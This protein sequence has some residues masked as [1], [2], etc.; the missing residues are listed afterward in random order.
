MGKERE[1]TIKSREQEEDIMEETKK[2]TY[3]YLQSV[4]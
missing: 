4:F 1:E 2:Q 3:M